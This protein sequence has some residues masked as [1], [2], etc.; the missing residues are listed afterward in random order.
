MAKTKQQKEG[1][2]QKFT[3]NVANSKSIV[4]TINKGI[5]SEEMTI[6]RKKL[7]QND[8]KYSVSKK[9]LLQIALKN[10]N[11]DL[12]ENIPFDGAINTVF[13][14]KDEIVGPK[15]IYELTKGS[16]KVEIIGGIF[17]GKYVDKEDIIKLA[18]MP[19][20]EQLLSNLVGSLNAPISGFVNVV[21]GNMRN[22]VYA[23]KAIAD[24]KGNA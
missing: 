10:Q 4:F 21:I 8:A 17:Q 15:T 6:I 24:K 11:I 22:F 7:V 3:E 18:T 20:R 12:P 14:Y 16:E 5:N 2:L 9:T 13:S 19:S 23:L 1:I